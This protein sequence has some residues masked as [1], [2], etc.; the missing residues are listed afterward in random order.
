M[1]NT[2]TSPINILVFPFQLLHFLFLRIGFPFFSGRFGMSLGIFP[3]L[4]HPTHVTHVLGKPIPMPEDV[5]ST[6]SITEEQVDFVFDAYKASVMELFEDN[7]GLLPPDVA[8][9]GLIIEW[10]K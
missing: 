1:Q 4:P 2:N 5:I 6:K 10:R 7:K 8:A 9:R 3:V